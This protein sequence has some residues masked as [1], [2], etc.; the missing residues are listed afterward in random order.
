M[1]QSLL[2]LSPS[3][4]CYQVDYRM[5]EFILG[6]VRSGKSR[7]A[8]QRALESGYPVTY[9]ATA[10]AGDDEMKKRI[11]AHQRQRCSSWQTL[12]EPYH[13][14]LA[15]CANTRPQHCVIVDCLTLWL[16][17]LLCNR[18]EDELKRQYDELILLLPSL[19]GCVIFVANETNMGVMPMGDLTRRYCDEA[20][21]LHQDIA[22][23]S[24][25]VTLMIAGIPQMLKEDER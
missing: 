8:D 3:S 2:T 12:E 16:C 23:I 10:L 9:I 14:A 13:L 18:G 24:N 11:D 5:V 21:R 4:V 1:F 17:N 7:F 25:R 15:L 20:G 22:R 19:P 6:G